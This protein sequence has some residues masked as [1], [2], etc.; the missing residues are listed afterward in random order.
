MHFTC[1]TLFGDFV[2]KSCKA[3]HINFRHMSARPVSTENV[4]LLLNLLFI[5]FNII[6]NMYGARGS[7]VVKALCYKPEGRGFVTR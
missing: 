7:V 1:H 6:I 2:T 4:E 3:T 5:I